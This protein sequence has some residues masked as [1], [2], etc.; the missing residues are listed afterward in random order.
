MQSIESSIKNF[1]QV[2]PTKSTSVPYII[3][4]NDEMKNSFNLCLSVNHSITNPDHLTSIIYIYIFIYIIRLSETNS[5][6]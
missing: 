6:L 2:L 1:E 5:K 3:Q 4:E